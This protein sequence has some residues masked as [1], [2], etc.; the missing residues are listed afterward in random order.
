MEFEGLAKHTE[1]VPRPMHEFLTK[2]VHDL[3]T[4]GIAHYM[5]QVYNSNPIQ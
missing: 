1:G 2:Y 5:K 3:V 4:P